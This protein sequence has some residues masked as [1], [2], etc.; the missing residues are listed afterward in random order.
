[1]RGL[2]TGGIG[3]GIAT[4]LAVIALLVLGG[5]LAIVLSSPGARAMPMVSRVGPAEPLRATPVIPPDS[6][7]IP[8]A[9]RKSKAWRPARRLEQRRTGSV[10]GEPRADGMIKVQMPAMACAVERKA[11]R[12]KKPGGFRVSVARIA[13]KIFSAGRK[14]KVDI[15]VR[16]AS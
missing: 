3:F 8:A 10:Q 13:V 9:E 1:M 11:D 14:K 16:D 7:P 6:S 5:R 2:K 12:T 4:A 15:A